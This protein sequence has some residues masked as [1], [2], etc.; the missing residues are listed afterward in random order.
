MTRTAT[1]IKVYW[2]NQDRYNEGWAYRLIDTDGDIE[3]GAIDAPAEDLDAAIGEAIRIADIDIRVDDFSRE[4]VKEG[5]YAS[6]MT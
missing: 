1:E 5:G 6:W 2:D 3:S 4:S